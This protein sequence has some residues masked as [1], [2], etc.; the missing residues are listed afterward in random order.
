ME[1]FGGGF[2]SGKYVREGSS[3]RGEGRLET[4]KTSD[5]RLFERFTDRNWRILDALV[6]V[7]DKWKGCQPRSH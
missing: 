4:E 6:D 7:A 3:G 2:S 5:N 1:P